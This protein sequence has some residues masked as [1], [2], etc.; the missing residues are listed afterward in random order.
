MIALAELEGLLK[1]QMGLDAASIG[2]SAIEGA[3]R[4]R[5]S[6]CKLPDIA[7]YREFVSSSEQEMQELIEAIVVPE[8]WFFRDAEA[9]VALARM[10]DDE[11]LP[12]HASG[13][14]RLL[15]LPCSTGEEPYSMA[16]ALL[17]ARLPADRFRI[18]A[19]DIS[20]RAID[21]AQAGIYGRNSFRGGDL[22]FRERHFEATSRGHRLAR[23]VRQQVHF[24]QGNLFDAQFPA[25]GG[26]YDAI[27]CRNILIY[28]DNATQRHAIDMLEG[29]LAPGGM[30]FVA[31]AESALL[32]SHDFRPVKN[33]AACVFRRAHASDAPQVH[34]PP[35]RVHARQFSVRPTAFTA[36]SAPA[37]KLPQIVSAAPAAAAGQSLDEVFR[38]ANLGRLDDASRCCRNYLE[39]HGQ[40]AAAFHAMGLISDASG[41]SFEAATC[42]R[43]A[44]YLD[45][46]NQEALVHLALTLEKLGDAQNALVF[47]NR[48]RRLRDREVKT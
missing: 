35:H 47:R 32:L 34:A 11:W 18:D 28:F 6:A 26:S 2:S 27:F 48:A 12:K 37:P 36:A 41:N 17:D 30:L 42:Y 38:L 33:A 45:P 23:A 14:L 40:S 10:V 43:K 20:Q 9:F 19:I 15:S 25:R 1:R 4:A 44:L 3:V 16:M 29:L 22:D 24:R 7:A 8:T 5:V 21:V 31:P 39:N 46:N 13:V